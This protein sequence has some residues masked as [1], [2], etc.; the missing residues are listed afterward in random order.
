MRKL[1]SAGEALPCSLQERR[2]RYPAPQ[3]AEEEE[4]VT[5]SESVQKDWWGIERYYHDVSSDE[6]DS[7]EN[8]QAVASTSGRTAG[9]RPR[10]IAA[11][12]KGQPP[13][14]QVQPYIQL[15]LHLRYSVASSD[16][17]RKAQPLRVLH[18]SRG[19]Q[20]HRMS[21]SATSPPKSTK[22]PGPSSCSRSDPAISCWRAAPGCRQSRSLSLPHSTR[23]LRLA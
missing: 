16:M 21:C 7:C 20:A 9:E 19:C 11:P 2:I 22:P 12:A 5:T 15:L 13:K 1:T 4:Q 18:A 23:A 8:S 6:E 3:Y 17:Y 10:S 14:T